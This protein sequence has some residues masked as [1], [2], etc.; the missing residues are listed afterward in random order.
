MK[1]GIQFPSPLELPFSQ[2]TNQEQQAEFLMSM[3]SIDEIPYGGADKMSRLL[4][5]NTADNV[6]CTVGIFRNGHDLG[7]H[8]P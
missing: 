1:T 7:L 3:L 2:D 4:D 6:P 8:H 5:W